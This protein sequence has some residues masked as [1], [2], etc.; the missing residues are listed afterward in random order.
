MKINIKPLSV[1][2][3]FQGRRFKTQDY[4]D[5]EQEAFYLLSDLLTI[6]KGDLELKLEV[7]LSS[8]L[9]DL[10]NI[11][12]PFIDILQKKYNFNDKRIFKLIM[13][14]KIVKKKAEYIDF[15]FKKYEK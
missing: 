6:S 9:A 3:C 15:K 12:K 2:K 13:V 1:N 8:K 10:D 4:K 11:A 7:G 14:K 5:Y